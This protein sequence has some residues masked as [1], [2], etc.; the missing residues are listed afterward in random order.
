[1]VAMRPA[2]CQQGV[3]DDEGAGVDQGV[4]RDALFALELDDRVERRTRGLAPDALPQRVTQAPQR[5]SQRE[6]LGNALD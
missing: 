4:A 2:A 6:D 5:Q 3:G 1:M